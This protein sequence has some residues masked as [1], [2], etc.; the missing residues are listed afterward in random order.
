MAPDTDL[1]APA[2]VDAAGSIAAGAARSFSIG[3]WNCA[4]VNNNPFEYIIE[5][6]DEPG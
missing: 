2:Q 1:V 6:D 5:F 4:A 3:S